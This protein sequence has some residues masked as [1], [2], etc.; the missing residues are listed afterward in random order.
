[1]AVNVFFVDGHIAAAIFNE[2]NEIGACDIDGTITLCSL[3]GMM[4]RCPN[5]GYEEFEP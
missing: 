4:K 3:C 2:L 1:M 5:Y